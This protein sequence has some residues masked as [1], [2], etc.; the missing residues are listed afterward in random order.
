MSSVCLAVLFSVK[1]MRIRDSGT[2]CGMVQSGGSLCS[3][4]LL[5]FIF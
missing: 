5:V 1:F 4:D 3:K 2:P